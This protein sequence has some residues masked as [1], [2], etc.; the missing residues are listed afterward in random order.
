MPFRPSVL[1]VLG[2]SNKSRGG[3][4]GPVSG[5]EAGAEISDS[6]ESVEALLW[7]GQSQRA[8]L[9]SEQRGRNRTHL[10]LIWGL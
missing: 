4:H 5:A 7:I 10:P 8:G 3:G 2:L 1:C 9:S 6:V